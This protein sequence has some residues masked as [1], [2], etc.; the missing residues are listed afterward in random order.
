MLTESL[1]NSKAELQGFRVGHVTG[2]KQ[3][4]VAQIVAD[5]RFLAALR[6]VFGASA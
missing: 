4:L 5:R 3:G 1:V 2:E 6:A